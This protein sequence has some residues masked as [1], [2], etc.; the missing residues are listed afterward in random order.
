MKR[1]LII[2]FI[3]ALLALTADRWGASLLTLITGARP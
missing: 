3:I 2:S 1:A